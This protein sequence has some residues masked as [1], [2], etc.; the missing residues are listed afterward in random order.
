MLNAIGDGN[1]CTVEIVL[2]HHLI[3]DLWVR[4]FLRRRHFYVVCD[5]NDN[6]RFEYLST[7]CSLMSLL[8]INTT[9]T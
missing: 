3:H 4:I 9:N 8:H 2:P 7:C 6:L 5:L 1:S